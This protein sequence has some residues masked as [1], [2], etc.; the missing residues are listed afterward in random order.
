M[1]SPRTFAS[2]KH[3][4]FLTIVIIRC[5]R[6]AWCGAHKIQSSGLNAIAVTAALSDQTMSPGSNLSAA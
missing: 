5:T 2:T 3:L 6:T 1:E 4:G